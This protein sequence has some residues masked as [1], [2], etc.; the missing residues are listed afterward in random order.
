MGC[1]VQILSIREKWSD[2]SKVRPKW[3]LIETEQISAWSQKTQLFTGKTR[4]EFQM[5]KEYSGPNPRDGRGSMGEE[6]ANSARLEWK[7]KERKNMTTLDTQKKSSWTSYM[8][9]ELGPSVKESSG[10]KSVQPLGWDPEVKWRTPRGL[11]CHEETVPPVRKPV[12][13][14]CDYNRQSTPFPR[15]AHSFINKKITHCLH[16]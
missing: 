4:Q 9:T 12:K 5:G 11:D 7:R 3:L 1:C 14:D 10:Y 8:F 16:A 15:L 13:G 6:V 2:Q